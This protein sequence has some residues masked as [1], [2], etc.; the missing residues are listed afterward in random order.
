MPVTPAMVASPVDQSALFMSAAAASTLSFNGSASFIFIRPK[1]I[2]GIDVITIA[3]I[4][5][6]P[7]QNVK[8]PT[9]MIPIGGR[10]PLRRPSTASMLN[11]SPIPSNAHDATRWAAA[12][13]RW[14]PYGCLSSGGLRALRVATR[15]ASGG[16]NDSMSSAKAVRMACDEPAVNPTITTMPATT[17]SVIHSSLTAFRSA[18]D[19][20]AGRSEWLKL[21]RLMAPVPR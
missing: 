1:I 7:D 8:P 6:Q 5:A 4:M 20:S 12:T 18:S 16:R 11:H 17:A 15:N 13:E 2:G 19:Y 21:E 14:K 10:S 9:D 3:A